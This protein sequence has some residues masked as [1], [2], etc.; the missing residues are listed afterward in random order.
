MDELVPGLEG[1]ADLLPINLLR[2]FFAFAGADRGFDSSAMS[3]VEDRKP[4]RSR[5]GQK[6]IIAR[7][8][9]AND[10]ERGQV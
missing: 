9:P 6:L 5:R 3:E 8:G 4:R 1:V 7:G 2:G 10:P